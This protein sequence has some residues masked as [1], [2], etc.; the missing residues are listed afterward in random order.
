MT[1]MT[2]AAPLTLVLPFALP[3]AALAADLVKAL[4]APNLAVLLGRAN[5]ARTV[6]ENLHSLPHERWLAGMLGRGEAGF[7]VAAM[8]SFG[9]DPGGD[10][11]LIVHPAHI[12]IAR[13]HLLMT[14][15]RRLG[16]VESHSRA[17]FD[18]ARPYF[19][20]DG[21]TLLYGD[22][23]T[24]FMR[25]G[26]WAD[27]ATTSPDATAGTSLTDA[28]PKGARAVAYRK[29]QN[30][31]QMLWHGHPA[32]AERE[33]RGLAAINGFWPWAC[34]STAGGTGTAAVVALA[35]VPGWMAALGPAVHTPLATW[36][37][38]ADRPA[39]LLDGVLMEA[40]MATD[41]AAWLQLMARLD[42]SLFAPALAAVDQGVKLD[43]ILTNRSEQLTVHCSAGTFGKLRNLWRSPSLACLLP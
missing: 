31:V 15:M 3:P 2:A 18:S 22:A 24:W 10:Q 5:A 41:W 33:A 32:N 28:M 12:E 29:L 42:Q 14:D 6:D 38:Q 13:T 16:L 34:A 36:L 11:W 20:E 1:V 17:L 19:D 30:E 35:N 43:L 4:A 27:L 21:H 7:A 8:P 26:D 40:A 9:L 37:T 25:A 39:A 23:L